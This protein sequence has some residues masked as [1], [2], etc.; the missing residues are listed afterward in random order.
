VDT[1]VQSGLVV[2]PAT[3]DDLTALEKFDPDD[4]WEYFVDRLERQK[5]DRGTLLVAWRDERI[6]GDIYL[7][8][9]EADEPEITRF[10]P[11]VPLLQRARVLPALRRQG[12]GTAMVQAAEEL[13]WAEHDRV[14]LAVSPDNTGAISLYERLG[15]EEWQERLVV[16]CDPRKPKPGEPLLTEELCLVLV[17]SLV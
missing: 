14:A 5:S 8:T 12:I 7:W 13:L 3:Y 15:Y 2:K 17:K 9:E 1:L 16:S 4:D 10:L 6:V 11:G